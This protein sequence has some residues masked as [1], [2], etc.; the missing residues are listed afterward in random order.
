[1]SALTVRG[2]SDETH[3][4]LKL[5]AQQNGRSVAAEVRRII[6]QAVQPLEEPRNL[7]NMLHAISQR[8]GVTQEDHDA[9]VQ[10]LD[11]VD[12]PIAEPVMFEERIGT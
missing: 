9:L 10:A 12:Q 5:R 4:A 1:M 3:R 11:E 2:L 7:G 6:A 8:N